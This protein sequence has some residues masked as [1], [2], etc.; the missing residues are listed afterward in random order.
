MN[1]EQITPRMLDDAIHWQVKRPQTTEGR[2]ALVRTAVE[3]PE[4]LEYIC[5]A[6]AVILDGGDTKSVLAGA[7]SLGIE[8]GMAMEEMQRRPQA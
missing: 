1:V 5:M 6:H 4:F 7:L 3:S 2:I 8:I